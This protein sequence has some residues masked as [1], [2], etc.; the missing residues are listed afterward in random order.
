MG[1]KPPFSCNV[2][3]FEGYFWISLFFHREDSKISKMTK[4][5]EFIIYFPLEKL[6]KIVKKPNDPFLHVMTHIQFNGYF[7]L[8]L[9]FS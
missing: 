6:N 8:L 2:P 3:Y 4:N 1:Q 5:D 9:C 7:R